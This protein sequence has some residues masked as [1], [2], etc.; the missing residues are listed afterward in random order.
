MEE[1]APDKLTAAAIAKEL[2]LSE[3]KVKKAITALALEP[4]AKKGVC[5]YYART[6]ME[7]IRGAVK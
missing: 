5:C 4:V 7:A 1:A 2:G 6:S 3:G